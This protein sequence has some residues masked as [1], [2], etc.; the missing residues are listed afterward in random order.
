MKLIIDLRED[1]LRLF[2]C[3]LRFSGQLGFD[4]DS[5]TRES[6]I[7]NALTSKNVSYE[8]VREEFCK[9]LMTKT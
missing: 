6:I 7:N 5:I 4:I 1:A 3:A 8:R 9:I 2:W